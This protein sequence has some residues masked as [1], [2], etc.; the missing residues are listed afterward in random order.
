MKKILKQ[1][2]YLSFLMNFILGILLLVN[3][4]SPAQAR[5]LAYIS[6]M[7]SHFISVIDT[8]QNP[9]TALP[10]IPFL[11]NTEVAAPGVAVSP[12]GRFAYVVSAK[13][14]GTPAMPVY[15][16][17]LNIIDTAQQRITAQVEVGPTATAG[18]AVSPNGQYVYV[19]NLQANHVS[20]I[21]TVTHRKIA[22]VPVPSPYGIA[23]SPDSKWV[24]VANRQNNR[25]DMIDMQTSP[26]STVADHIP[27]SSP[28]TGIAISPNGNF[29]Y[30]TSNNNKLFFVGIDPTRQQG[31]ITSL[32]SLNLLGIPAGIAIT[33]DGRYLYVAINQAYSVSVIDTNGQSSPSPIVVAQN[34]TGIAIRSDG[35]F[36][37]VANYGSNTVSV[38]DTSTN[39]KLP[40]DI[41]VGTQ[42]A[43]FGNFITPLVPSPFATCGNNAIDAGED[44]DGSNLNSKTCSNSGFAG[45]GNL[46][47]GLNCA[48]DTSACVSGNPPPPSSGGCA[49]NPASKASNLVYWFSGFSLAVLLLK[50]R[51]AL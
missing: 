19:A 12:N 42:P 4:T 11:T 35:Q 28:P 44:C 46:S 5:A 38:I 48:F 49:L 16:Y 37:Y 20:I 29:L 3:F 1:K 15:S 43:A 41:A 10:S 50:R 45:G 14:T 34:P 23:V 25:I 31:L 2:S 27:L 33:P 51:N 30:V 47:C 39:T 26:I 21:N 17:S 9:P 32:T 24:Y 8:E 18:I 22:D 6:N 36:V 7:G 40:A 13:Q